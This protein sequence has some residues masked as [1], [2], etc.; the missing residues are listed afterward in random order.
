[1]EMAADFEKDTG[2]SEELTKDQRIK[3]KVTRLKRLLKD[4]PADR[5]KAV[6]GLVKR[7]AFMEVA[8]ED[9]EAD[10]N[11]NGTVEVFSQTPGI[12]YERERPAARIY[13]T[14]IKNYT[15]ACKQLFDLLPNDKPKP[16]A[17]ELM[18][19]VKGAKK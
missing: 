1:M 11:Q 18:A 9:L 13:N 14:T 3:K 8:L 19:F 7:I 10:I 16:E 5:M 4:L 2:K 15:S 12:E 6:D 17:D